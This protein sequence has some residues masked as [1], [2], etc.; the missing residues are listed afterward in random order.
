M[1]IRK[2]ILAA[3][4]LSATV[5]LSACAGNGSST[6]DSAKPI[7]GKQISLAQ[8]GRF[9]SID[10]KFDESAAEIVAYDPDTTQVFV[11]NAQQG[12]VDVLDLSD[13]AHPEKVGTIFAGAHL[14]EA[15]AIN[16][17]SVSDG[18]VAVA[19]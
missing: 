1:H 5:G 4:I 14:P 15:G 18:R 19:V 3:A 11:V 16:S 8:I 13:P 6:V 7:A 2:S 12:A 9:T 17:V 10:N